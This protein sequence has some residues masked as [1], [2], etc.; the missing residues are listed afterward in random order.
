MVERNYYIEKL[1]DSYPKLL[2][3]LEEVL[4]AHKLLLECN[5]SGNKILTCGNGGSAADAEHIV[6][7][8][9][10]GFRLRRELT[11]E[12]NQKIVELYPA[13][14][15]FLSKNLQQ[16]IPAISLVSSI[17]LS[18]AFSNDVNP[19][20]IFA[21][22]IFGLGKLGD[23][24]IAISTSGNSINIIQAAKIARIKN[25]KVIGLT[26]QSGGELEK[27]ADVTI[28]APAKDVAEIQEYHL[29]IY[30]CLC[31]MLEAE[32]FAG[33]GRGHGAVNQAWKSPAANKPFQNVR[34]VIFD[35]DGV[36]TDNKVYTA[37]DGV[38]SVA[39]DRGDSLGI[40]MLKEIGM[41][42][43]ILSTETNPVV[44]ARAKKIGVKVE[45]GCNNKKVF[46]EKYLS[47]NKID[48]KNVIYVG[49]DLNDLEAMGLVGYPVA[50]SDAHPDVIRIATHVLC[51]SGGHGA[52]RELCELLINQRED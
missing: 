7:E 11:E 4:E 36:F 18:T 16:A 27:H 3:V 50:P 31:S 52:V 42:M 10:K 1:I 49:N 34:L 2:I 8:L 19:D 29:P 17:S 45:A 26:G 40:N 43:F 6:G 23:V 24:V 5:A 38:E 9:M 13:E 35:F 47:E 12:Q 15:L 39:C 37:Q 48:S 46:L 14:A 32:I 28:R 20:F 44:M 41:D 51:N 33:E 30:H 21:Q 25:M 22:Q